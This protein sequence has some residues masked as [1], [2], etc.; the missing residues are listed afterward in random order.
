MQAAIEIQNG[1]RSK[2]AQITALNDSAKIL[3]AQIMDPMNTDE[4]AKAAQRSQLAA[5]Q[6]RFNELSGVET[7]EGIP[8]PANPSPSNLIKDKIYQTPTGL[9]KWTGTGF[10]PA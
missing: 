10:V 4:N 8:L 3:N 1:A 7:K 5:I 6:K 2:Q 9:H